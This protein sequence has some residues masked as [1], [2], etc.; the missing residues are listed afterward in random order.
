MSTASEVVQASPVSRRRLTIG[1]AVG[2]GVLLIALV[3]SS[4]VQR[5]DTALVRWK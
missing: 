3:S 5:V 1:A 4:L 2:A